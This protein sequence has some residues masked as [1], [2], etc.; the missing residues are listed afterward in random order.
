MNIAIVGIT[1]S[2]GKEM[3]NCIEDLNIKIKNLFLYASKKS[4][5]K[6]I[7]FNHKRYTVKEVKDD[8]F[9]DVDVALFAVDSSLSIKYFELA[10]KFNCLV[11][12]NSSAFRLDNRYPLVI[13]EINSEL[14]TNNNGLIANPNCSTILLNVVLWNI[15][16]KYGINRIVVS[17]YQAA[18]GAGNE[19]INELY[20]QNIEL[21][22][23]NKVVSK[24][25]FGRQ[26]VNNVFSHNSKINIS[27]GYNEEELKMINETKKILNDDK[28]KIS[29]TCVRV[30]VYRAHS[31]SVNITL[32]KI[33]TE[34]EIRE[35]LNASD[36]IK[37][38]DDRYN[39][40]FPE[41]LI[42]SN[43]HDVYVGRIRS[44]L[45]QDEGYGFELFISGDQILKGAALNAVQILKYV[46]Q[47]TLVIE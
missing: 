17:T 28:I 32:S 45:G 18:S 33:A 5:G 44:D 4:V 9:K 31:E 3:L 1:G 40:N 27:N 35:T 15:Y 42:S 43:Q 36:G 13:P 25:I 30:P 23:N 34:D 6:T 24:D 41:P 14:I 47:N 12:D 22:N 19:G 8:S 20:N 46:Q 29:V 38:L 2:V 26:Y 21:L 11:I 39:N 16:K 37:I 7:L 10:K